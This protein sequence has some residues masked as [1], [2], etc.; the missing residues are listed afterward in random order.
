MTA[1]GSGHARKFIED[2]TAAIIS[3]SKAL[4]PDIPIA[5][6]A[7]QESAIR[8]TLRTQRRHIYRHRAAIQ[9]P[10]CQAGAYGWGGLEPRAAK[11]AS[12]VKTL[13]SS[14]AKKRAHIGREAIVPGAGALQDAPLH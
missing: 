6:F 10:F 5:M 2:L 12:Q 9:N 8:K 11:T 7:M 4:A 3:L 14:R 13:R 1:N